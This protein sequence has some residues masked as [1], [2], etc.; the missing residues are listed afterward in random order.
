MWPNGE[1]DLAA[2]APWTRRPPSDA[3]ARFEAPAQAGCD[4]DAWLALHAIEGHGAVAKANTERS[5]VRI[6]CSERELRADQAEENHHATPAIQYFS[7][8]VLCRDRA[9]VRV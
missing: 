9:L 7:D 5:S 6:G 8:A 4:A 1:C 2:P 3:L